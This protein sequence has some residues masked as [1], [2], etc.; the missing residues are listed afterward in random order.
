MTDSAPARPR[1]DV[2]HAARQARQLLRRSALIGAIA[3]ALPIPGLDWL[4]D[5]ALLARLLPRI[6]RFFG[7][8]PEQIDALDPG[9]REQVQKAAAMVSSVLIGKLITRDMVV[10]L[11]RAAGMRLTATQA[12]RYVPLAG[13]AAAAAIGYATL[14]YLGERHIQDCMRVAQEAQLDIPSQLQR[15]ARRIQHTD[16][17]LQQGH[18]AGRYRWWRLMPRTWRG[19]R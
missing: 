5:T 1:A 8:T 9:K 10:R 4:V 3:S 14:R 2:A 12:A 6:N 7:L 11:A 15:T 19:T 16:H 17:E 13:Q 18:T